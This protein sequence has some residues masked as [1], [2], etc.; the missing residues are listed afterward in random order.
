MHKK[1]KT[2]IK[3]LFVLVAIPVSA[4]CMHIS[5][6]E[7]EYPQNAVMKRSSECQNIA[8]LFKMAEIAD[9]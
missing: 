8:L 1:T 7:N 5:K 4:S 2:L 3:I 9:L 6:S